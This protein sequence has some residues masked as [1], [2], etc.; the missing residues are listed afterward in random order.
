MAKRHQDAEAPRRA[1]RREL[2]MRSAVSG[3]I[4]S[5]APRSAVSDAASER[6]KVSR[7]GARSKGGKDLSKER[8]SVPANAHY[9]SSAKEIQTGAQ[10][11][12]IV[13]SP[14]AGR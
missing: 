3:W 9:A 1:E 6:E 13:L 4:V 11:A 14:R 10:S 2:E 8:A 7:N 5:G 12:L